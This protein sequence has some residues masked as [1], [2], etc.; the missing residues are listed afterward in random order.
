MLSCPED[1]APGYLGSLYLLLLLNKN[2]NEKR[3]S[4]VQRDEA[5]HAMPSCLGMLSQGNETR[6]LGIAVSMD[7]IHLQVGRSSS[8]C[9]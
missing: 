6:C 3:S 8:T 1:R 4:R 5:M 9:I 7:K 2:P